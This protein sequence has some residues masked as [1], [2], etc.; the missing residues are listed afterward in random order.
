MN[1]DDE[2]TTPAT[3]DGEGM[4]PFERL[5]ATA[6]ML[7]APVMIYVRGPRTPRPAATEPTEP[8]W[9]V[10]VQLGDTAKILGFGETPAEALDN[11]S[12]GQLLAGPYAVQS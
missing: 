11:A 5:V 10:L 4:G 8:R 3:D 12:T 9:V 6:S 7:E 2:T 1:T